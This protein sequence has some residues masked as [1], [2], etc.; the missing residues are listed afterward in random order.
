MAGLAL[1]I[2]LFLTGSQHTSLLTDL[3]NRAASTRDYL[4][5]R[6]GAPLSFFSAKP[7]L[8]DR[9]QLQGIVYSPSKPVAVIN[10]QTCASGELVAVPV[11]RDDEVIHCLE[12]DRGWV[13]I[14]TS[15]GAEISLRLK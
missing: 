7:S 3:Y 15:D 14:Q 11:G 2:M 4:V 9:F 5:H 10:R 6:E 12:I 8:T 1:S 13:E